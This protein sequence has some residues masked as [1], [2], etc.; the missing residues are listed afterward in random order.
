M[1]IRV[2]NINLFAS[3]EG[4]ENAPLIL[5]LHGG[6][7]TSDHVGE[8]AAFKMLG[9]QFRI[10]AYDQRGCGRSQLGNEISADQLIDDLEEVRLFLGGSRPVM[11]IGHSYGGII[12]LQHALRHPGAVSH[13]VLIGC[14]LSHHFE[15]TALNEFERRRAVGAPAANADMVEKQLRRGFDSETEYR[16]VQF[17]LSGLYTPG[18]SLEKALASATNLSRKI[19]IEVH[20][21]LWMGPKYD[22]RPQLSKLRAKLLAISGELDWLVPPSCAEELCVLVPSARYVIVPGVGHYCHHEAQDAVLKELREFLVS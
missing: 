19:D 12:A 16:I 9:D 8:F 2:N 22:A 7:G 10:V 6:R 14:P 5:A 13:L 1:Y 20:K 17:A 4:D 18:I 15:E 21:R 11:V 3:A